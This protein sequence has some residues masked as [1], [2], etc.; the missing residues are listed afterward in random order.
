MSDKPVYLAGWA[1]KDFSLSEIEKYLLSYK[2]PI[3]EISKDLI[4]KNVSIKD[5]YRLIQ[6]MKLKYNFEIS[7]AGTT[8]FSD[9]SGIPFGDYLNYLSIQASQAKF[10]GANYF[11]IM[12]GGNIQSLVILKRLKEFEETISPV[13][14]IIEIHGGWESSASNIKQ[15]ITQTEYNF[16]ID[17]QNVVHAKLSY[18]ELKY[19]IPPERIQYYHSRNY[20][21]QH[22]ED[23][24]SLAEENEWLDQVQNHR[25]VL[26]EPKQINKNQVIEILKW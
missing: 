5:I 6:N 7:Y 16:V 25:V 17:F 20:S 22:I 3:F 4:N 11:R 15:I 2:P 26:W 18:Q 12:V 10:L 14:I 21:D 8:D 1:T 9:S 13:K 24:E 23:E 19:L